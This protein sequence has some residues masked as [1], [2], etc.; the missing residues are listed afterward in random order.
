MRYLVMIRRT[1]T[2]YSV[3]VPDLPGCV[4]TGTTVEHSRQMIAEA[5]EMHLELM[6]QAGESIP[7]P[8]Q[9]FA[10]A[11]DESSPEE[12]CTWVEVESPHLAAS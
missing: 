7:F 8:S 12:L 2:G 1:G 6:Q 4:A 9:C 10:F 5:I 3:D 11:V